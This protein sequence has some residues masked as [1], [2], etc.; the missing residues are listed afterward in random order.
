MNTYVNKP[1]GWKTRPIIAVLVIVVTM[2]VLQSNAFA[3]TA[4]N[5]TITNTAAVSWLDGD[6]LNPANANASVS[7]TVNLLQATPTLSAPAD[8]STAS[9]TAL[10]YTY[11]I[12]TNANGQ[13]TYT[14]T[15]SFVSSTGTYSSET[16]EIR[17]TAGG[18]GSII[19]SVTLGATTAAAIA[20]SGTAVI[21]VPADGAS[22]ASI[23][24]IAAGD[25]LYIG[26]ATYTVASITD[27]ATGTSTITLTTNLAANVNVADL[28]A[29]QQTFYYR[30]TPVAIGSGTVTNT[31]TADDTV[32][33][34]AT[35]TTVT[36]IT[37]S[38][39]SVTVT[40]Y[41]RNVTTGTAGTGTPISYDSGGG[42]NN[43]YPTG[44]TGKPGD[45][46]EY[47]IQ[48]ANA[49]SGGGATAVIITDPVPAYTTYVASSM[50]LDG[51]ALTDADADGDA[52]ETDGT[53]V[54]IYAGD[55]VGNDG[56]AGV[57]NGT[58]GTLT[59]G[60]TTRGSFQVTIQ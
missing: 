46:L 24:G 35:D 49:G 48:V 33:A 45:V 22:D 28:I 19:G 30:V 60:T 52:G 36:T 38:A 9:G 21:T 54:Y 41:V 23:N 13:D 2:L 26:T 55:T 15:D 43:Y 51:V 27:N 44:V 20:N 37:L 10:D 34:V 12:R 50:T 5:A 3:A 25:T 47:V 42:A 31:V 1:P 29:E 18:A 59:S 58:G 8:A 14:L 17:D 53:T 4:A 39:P 32:S 7:V 40:K 57:G 11:T 56:A 16:T 6:G